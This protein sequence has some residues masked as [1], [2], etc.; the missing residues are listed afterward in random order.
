MASQITRTHPVF[1]V[2]TAP[3]TSNDVC[4]DANMIRRWDDQ[5][6]IA[7]IDGLGHGEEAAKASATAKRYLGE[8]FSEDLAEVMLGLDEH[9]TKTRGAVVGLARVDQAEKKFTFCGVG[10][11]EI[12]VV[13]DPPIHPVSTEG[14]VGMNRIR[15][16]KFEYRYVGLSSFALYSD[17]ISSNFELPASNRPSWEPQKLAEEILLKY[18]NRVDDATVVVVT[19]EQD[20]GWVPPV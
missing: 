4:G 7:V 14:V 1:G 20:R 13:S 8:V 12:K 10:N 2:A 19:W 3:A 18:W 11:I 16:K 5:L 6:F 15:L 17:G 9:L